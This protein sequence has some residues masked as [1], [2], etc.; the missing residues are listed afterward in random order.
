M[1]DAS[2]ISRAAV[3]R[4]ARPVRICVSSGADIYRYFGGRARHSVRAAAPADTI[5]RPR[6]SAM[7]GAHGVTRP[8]TRL[9][10]QYRGALPGSGH[11]LSVSIGVHRWLH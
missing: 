10:L 11:P 5:L 8:T 4:F 3:R 9:S 7:H 2:I 1:T 6:V